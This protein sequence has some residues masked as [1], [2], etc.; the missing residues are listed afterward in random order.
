MACCL[1]GAKPVPAYCQLD[2]WEKNHW[3]LNLNS[4]IFSQENAFENVKC[5]IGGHFLQGEMMSLLINIVILGYTDMSSLGFQF[6]SMAFDIQRLKESNIH[7]SCEEMPMVHFTNG[8]GVDNQN[9]FLCSSHTTSTNPIMPQFCT[10]HDSTAVMTYMCKI[11]IWFSHWTQNYRKKYFHKIWIM[12]SLLRCEIGS[13][14]FPV[15]FPRKQFLLTEVHW[16]NKN[17]IQC[18]QLT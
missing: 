13:V 9:L 11:V 12:S 10:S 7:L 16:V 5:Q 4:I 1:F 2:S 15:S 6:I 8:L 17:S 3:N 18:T 14:L